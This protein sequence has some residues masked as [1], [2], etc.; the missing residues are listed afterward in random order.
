MFPNVR[1][2]IAA[3]AASIVAL[4]CGFGV[5]AAFRVNHEPLARLPSTPMQFAR[6]ND[7]APLPAVVPPTAPAAGTPESAAPVAIAPTPAAQP[8]QAAA[9]PAPVQQQQ[10]LVDTVPDAKAVGTSTPTQPAS[11]PMPVVQ[12]QPALSDALPE[13]KIT[14]ADTQVVAAAPAAPAAA[15]VPPAIDQ[16]PSAAENTRDSETTSAISGS[17]P[18]PPHDRAA[19]KTAK[20]HAHRRVA[21][22]QP[23]LSP[24]RAT[25]AN[26]A[27]HFITA[28]PEF[29]SAPP[30]RVRHVRAVSR[31]RARREPAVGGPFV[32]AKPQ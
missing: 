24:P 5:F 8:A 12:Q 9:E 32:A 10:T 14:N 21:G 1:L 29:R 19:K 20:R 6:G 15:V 22:T 13:A 11:A 16:A 28:Q 27:P 7:V 26:I 3:I 2:M 4:S 30:Q 17:E 25:A 23:W 31:A 18:A